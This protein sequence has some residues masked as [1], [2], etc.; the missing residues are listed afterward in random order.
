M[1]G[2]LG[3]FGFAEP[4]DK[5]LAVPGYPRLGLSPRRSGWEEGGFAAN[6]A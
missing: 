1:R 4:C 3:G 5:R 2:Q 6:S